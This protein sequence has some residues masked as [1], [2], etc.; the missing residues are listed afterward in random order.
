[1]RAS[2]ATPASMFT[3]SAWQ[4]PVW[5]ICPGGQVSNSLQGMPLGY[6]G[7]KHVASMST[8]V[9]SQVPESKTGSVR[10]AGTVL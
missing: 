1:M 9:T 5:H 4:I 10:I 8:K 7:A 3:G 2:M 6:R